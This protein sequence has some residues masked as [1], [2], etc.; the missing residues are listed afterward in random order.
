[1]LRKD[2]IVEVRQKT[3]E[4][5]VQALRLVDESILS[6][7]PFARYKKAVAEENA[8]LTFAGLGLPATDPKSM[9]DI[10]V[11]IRVLLTP[12]RKRG[13]NCLRPSDS[14]ENT[15]IEESDERTVAEC[16]TLHRR[17][18]IRGEPGS[19]KTTTLR[20]VAR[21]S[22]LGISTENQLPLKRRLPLMV[23]LAEFAKMCECDKEMT[24][25][26]FVVTRTLRDASPESWSQV[27]R[28]IE[29]ELQRGGCLVL[30]DGLDEVGGHERLAAELRKFI[31]KFGRNHFVLSSRIVGVD[32]APWRELNFAEYQVRTWRDKDIEDFARR[33]YSSRPVAGKAQKK[34]LEQRAK[35][36]TMAIMDHPPLR[37]IASNPLMLT[38]LAAL[39]YARATLPRRRVD[40]YAKIVE[41]MLE[42]WEANKRTARSG[43]PL[44]GIL[45]EG[46]EFSWLLER[47]ALGM[48]REGRVLR[49]RWWVSDH[50]RQFLRD[51]MAIDEN[52]VKEQSERVI[53]YLCERTGLLVERGEGIFGFGHR[54]FQ[55]YFAARGILLEVEAGGDIVSSL[56]PYL[57]H[58]QWQ[59][60]VVY[61]AAS[62]SALRA[63]A[64]MRVILDDPDPAGR[65]LRR[66]QRLALRCLA[67]GAI[68]AD[69]T[70]LGQVFSDGDTIGKSKWVG[71]GIGF[72]SLLKQLLVT[73]YEAAAQKMLSDILAA[74]NKHLSEEDYLALF[75]STCDLPAGPAEAA[76]GAVYEVQ[77]GGRPVELVWPARELRTEDPDAWYLEVLKLVRSSR[78]QIGHKMVLISLLSEE[79]DTHATAKN[80]LKNL[81]IHDRSPTIRAGAASALQDAMSTDATIGD[82]LLDRLDKDKSDEVRK[83]CAFSLR[84]IVPERDDVR[85]H[86]EHLFSSG[87]EAVRVGAARGLSRLDFALPKHKQLFERFLHT[88]TS[89]VEPTPV[90]CAAIRATASCLGRDDMKALETAVEGCLEDQDARVKIVSLHA[91]ADAIADGRMEWSQPMAE[92]IESMLMDVRDP[93]PHLF[94]D[95]IQIVAMKEIHGGKRL[96]HTLSDALAPFSSE[97]RIAF[98]FGSVARLGQVRDSDVDLMI[99]G[100]V[101][102]KDLAEALHAAENTLGRTINPVLFSAD[103]F[104]QQYREGNPLLFDVVRK[105]KIFIKGNR[106]ELTGLVAEGLS[107]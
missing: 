83:C 79:V 50:A 7:D 88:I 66:G 31:V 101:R 16:L 70:L 28:N 8:D 21:A 92:R 61:V 51:H 1:M 97:I 75:L 65:F 62:L 6:P 84:R 54:T 67:D 57:F 2:D 4:G 35:E 40:L 91:I 11:P 73:R 87:Q 59:E 74:G 37:A 107:A 81:L 69:R 38:I 82:L 78:I 23:R 71:I 27:E 24:L 9:D 10:Y 46:R 58:P 49:P 22:A 25:V 18:L 95:L 47:L 103:K 76:P 104:R 105:D 53:R 3:V 98:V 29:S 93:C 19:G 72:I 14:V 32:P 41:V 63:T 44:H 48:Q 100:D 39:H 85:E 99:V 20:H 26:R 64:L 96:E 89:F 30:L 102:L 34:D 52:L 60:V 106:D 80:I 13:D 56:R 5:L 17:V 77:L 12:G 55:E 42:T 68:I 15:P 86:L 43:D 36:L 90:R 45:F 94:G 33:W